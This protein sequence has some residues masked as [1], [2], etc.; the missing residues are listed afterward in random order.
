MQFLD[1][2]VFNATKGASSAAGREGE[3][4]TRHPQ[5]LSVGPVRVEA[6]ATCLA[7]GYGEDSSREQSADRSAS[8]S[9]SNSSLGREGGGGRSGEGPLEAPASPKLCSQVRIRNELITDESRESF[10]RHV[11]S[12]TRLCVTYCWPVVT[13]SCRV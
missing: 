8:G 9:A 5:L 1:N 13:F 12:A 11:R 7:L 4:Q 3:K 2:G 6:A 10:A